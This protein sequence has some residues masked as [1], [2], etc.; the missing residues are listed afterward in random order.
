M[1][2][3]Q[4]ICNYP[5]FFEVSTDRLCAFV[6]NC[7]CWCNSHP[8]QLLIKAS[9]PSDYPHFDELKEGLEVAKRIAVKINEA[10]RKAENAAIA[11]NLKDRVDDWKGLHV[12]NFGSLLLSGLFVVSKSEVD[13][14]YQI[15]LFEK[16]FLG[17]KE[18][19]G[20]T[21]GGKR[22]GKKNQPKPSKSNTRLLVTASIFINHITKVA[23]SCKWHTF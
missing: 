22:A 13:R 9:S 10:L 11:Q 23:H 3:I 18:S 21:A 17:F 14:E 20:T 7:A 19:D 5:L 15:F 1:K 16:I 2:P 8:T 6:H 12:S 4:R